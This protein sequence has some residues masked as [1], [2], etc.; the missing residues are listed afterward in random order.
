MRIIIVNKVK[1]VRYVMIESLTLVI[2]V[3]ATVS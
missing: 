2:S 1:L 3:E